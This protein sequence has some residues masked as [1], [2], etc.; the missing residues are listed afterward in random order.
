MLSTIPFDPLNPGQVFACLGFAEAADVL[1]APRP[2][3]S[4]G[5]R[6]RF[7]FSDPTQ[8]RFHLESAG[9]SPPVEV[10]LDYL[11]K[12]EVV[13]IGAERSGEALTTARWSISTDVTRVGEALPNGLPT[14]PAALPVE[15]RADGHSLCFVHWGDTTQRDKVKF[16]A[17]ASGYPGAALLRDALDLVRGRLRDAAD[18][19]FSLSAVQSSSFRFDWRRDYVPIDAGFSLNRHGS[20][21][22]VG[23]PLVEILAAYG[24]S[25]ARPKRVHKLRYVYGC[26]I[27]PADRLLPL[28][29][30][31]AGLGGDPLH[32]FRIRRFRMELAHPGRDDRCITHVYEETTS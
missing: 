32:P 25:N 31:R 30:L 8:P 6:A 14:S 20:I 18:S 27:D 7:D 3:A 12:A 16:W 1:R 26:L 23:F 22:T 5:V 15:L 29:L 19:P 10:V 21:Q 13:A 17:G 24:L 28:P 9:E 11:A 2:G 4:A